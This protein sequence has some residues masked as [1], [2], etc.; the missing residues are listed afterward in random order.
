MLSKLFQ[1]T[2]PRLVTRLSDVGNPV[3]GSQDVNH[4]EYDFVIIGGGKFL[5]TLSVLNGSDYLE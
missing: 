1:S 3:D 4:H 5:L 2:S